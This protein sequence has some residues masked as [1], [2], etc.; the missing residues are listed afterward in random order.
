MVGIIRASRLPYRSLSPFRHRRRPSRLMFFI[1]IGAIIGAIFG[2]WPGAVIG[3][4]I[5]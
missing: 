1:I 2:S 5:G 4:L 3:G